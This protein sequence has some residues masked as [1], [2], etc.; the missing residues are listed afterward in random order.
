[1]LFITMPI[2]FNVERNDLNTQC[3][4]KYRFLLTNREG[5]SGSFECNLENDASAQK[6]AASIV[7]G[8]TFILDAS[9]FRLLSDDSCGAIAFIATVNYNNL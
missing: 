4:M 3:I 1:M 5:A 9:V 7:L 2:L 6:M 8:V